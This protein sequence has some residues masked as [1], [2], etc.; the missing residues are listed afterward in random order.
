MPLSPV[1]HTALDMARTDGVAGTSTPT[2]PMVL[3]YLLN[4]T[5]TTAALI[6]PNGGTGVRHSL[7]RTVSGDLG[8]MFD[9]PSTVAFDADARS[10]SWTPR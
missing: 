2:L 4:P 7:R 9:A 3:E 1:E 8:S 6:G 5:P 10:W